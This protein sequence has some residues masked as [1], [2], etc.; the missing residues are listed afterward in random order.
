VAVII[1]RRSYELTNGWE[2]EPP[3]AVACF[4]VTHEVPAMW[5]TA[6]RCPPT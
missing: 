3:D 2:G 6:P 5:L 1:G 4:V